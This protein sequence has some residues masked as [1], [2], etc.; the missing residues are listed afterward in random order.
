[1]QYTA[2]ASIIETVSRGKA[3]PKAEAQR[4][5]ECRVEKMFDDVKDKEITD[6]FKASIFDN[7]AHAGIPF[8]QWVMNNLD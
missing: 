3:M 2:N 7:Y 5:L 1:M 8:I 4:I 6:A